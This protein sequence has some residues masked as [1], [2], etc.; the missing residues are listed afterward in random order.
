MRRIAMRNL[1]RTAHKGRGEPLGA[2]GLGGVLPVRGAAADPGDEARH[3]G[4]PVDPAVRLLRSAVRRLRRARRA[5]V[6]LPA[7]AQEPQ[8]LRDVRGDGAARGHDDRGRGAVRRPPRLHHVVGARHARAGHRAAAPLLRPRGE[9]VLPRGAHRQADR[10]RGHGALPPGH[11][12]SGRTRSP[13]PT[14]RRRRPSWST[15]PGSSCSASATAPGT[16]PSSSWGSGIDFGEAF[17]GN[18]GNAAVHDFT[19]VGDVVNTASRLQG[20][21]AGGEV[22]LSARLA[23]HLDD[24]DRRAGAA[25]AQ[26]QA[27]A[28]RRLPG[29]LV[30][31][32]IR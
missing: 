28:P 5:A 22:V 19:A 25:H 23:A 16:G 9:G 32:L 21:A 15:T 12:G 11:P 6:R 13:T 29:Q 2:G 18:I 27:R 10:R 17:I 24:A 30:P 8:H 31:G 4:A 20:Q 14:D 7:V 1:R 26:G 3:A